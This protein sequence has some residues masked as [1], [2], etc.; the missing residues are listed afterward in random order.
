MIREWSELVTTTHEAMK[1]KG[2]WDSPRSTFDIE[3]NFHAEISEAW[4]EYRAGRMA[5]WYGENGKP[6]GFWIELADLLIRLADACGGSPETYAVEILDDGEFSRNASELIADLHY[7]IARQ[8]WDEVVYFC[9][10]FAEANQIDLWQAIDE[11]AKYNATR[12]YRHGGK[13]A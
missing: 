12:S 6:E 8:L 5:T 3:N 11:K 13:I 2:W 7:A 1:A 10:A 4:E 9:F